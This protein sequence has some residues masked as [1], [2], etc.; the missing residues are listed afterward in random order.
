MPGGKEFCVQRD[1]GSE[2]AGTELAL[3]HL[4]EREGA[5]HALGGDRRPP[6]DRATLDSK[7]KEAYTK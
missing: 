3:W 5:L 7:N 1:F 4:L 6:V 2:P